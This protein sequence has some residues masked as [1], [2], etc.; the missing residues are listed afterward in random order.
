MRSIYI[1]RRIKVV[2]IIAS[3]LGV[4]YAE[5]KVYSRPTFSCV[6]GE[7]MRGTRPVW[8]IADKY[9][10][11]NLSDATHYVM[12]INNIKAKDLSVL[13]YNLIITI[14]EKKG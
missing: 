10:D 12:K 13:P 11:G 6:A 5:H 7:E 2:F 14:K 3:L 8:N 4:M 9:C 1:K